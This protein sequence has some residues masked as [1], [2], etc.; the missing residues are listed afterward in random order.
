MGPPTVII[1]SP[2]KKYKNHLMTE[3]PFLLE[4]MKEY[5]R[6]KF[7]YQPRDPFQKMI[8]NVPSVYPST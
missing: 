5:V 2:M 6:K 8:N 4:L 3:N 1:K 7:A